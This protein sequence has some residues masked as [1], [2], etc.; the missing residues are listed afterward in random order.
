MSK[1]I[2]LFHIFLLVIFINVFIVVVAI[3]SSFKPGNFANWSFSVS[4]FIQ[5]LVVEIALFGPMVV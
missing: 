1:K 4:D 2:K 3:I 5:L